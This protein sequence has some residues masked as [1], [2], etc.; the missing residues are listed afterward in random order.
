M[1][2]RERKVKPV[3]KESE[4]PALLITISVRAKCFVIFALASLP[5]ISTSS[6]LSLCWIMSWSFSFVKVLY[7]STLMLLL[8]KDILCKVKLWLFHTNKTVILMI[9]LEMISDMKSFCFNFFHWRRGAFCLI[10][11][12]GTADIIANWQANRV[13][14]YA[15]TWLLNNIFRLKLDL[16]VPLKISLQ[17]WMLCRTL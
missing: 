11:S 8:I 5:S 7:S 4:S 17:Q 6:T 12:A 16:L 13:S 15:S 1:L 9:Y 2:C 3:L 14:V 10:W